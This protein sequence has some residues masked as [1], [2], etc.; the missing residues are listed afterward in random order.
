MDKLT[1]NGREYRVECNWRALTGFLKE[2]GSDSLEKLS[3]LDKL[4]PTEW[5][6]LAECCISEGER[7]EGREYKRGAIGDLPIFEA[8]AAITAFMQIFAAQSQ[9]RNSVPAEE[10]KD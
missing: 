8:S 10:K 6:Q 5:E 4:S 1:I 9:P 2:C 7:L 3:G